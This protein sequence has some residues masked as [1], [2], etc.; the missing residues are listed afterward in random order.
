MG[1][2]A[3]QRVS[4]RTGRGSVVRQVRVNGRCPVGVCYTPDNLGRPRINAIL[5]WADPFP[6][7]TLEPAPEPVAATAGAAGA[8]EAGD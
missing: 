3:G 5:D 7:V 8:A 2:A 1:L 6:S 4:L